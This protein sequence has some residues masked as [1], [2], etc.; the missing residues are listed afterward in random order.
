MDR[1]NTDYNQSLYLNYPLEDTS[2][3]TKIFFFLYMIVVPV[4]F[5]GN[6]L[7]FC[8]LM[9]RETRKTSTAIY[10]IALS[11]VD[12]FCLVEGALV[13]HI[14]TSDVFLGWSGYLPIQNTL[15]CQFYTF[16]LYLNPNMSAWCLVSVTIERVMVIYFP[17]RYVQCVL[18]SFYHI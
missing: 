10:L 16:F 7:S 13:D 18:H 2:H 15:S 4:V 3:N 8:V 6:F 17:H 5:T 9:R 12:T 14:L 1:N 11:I